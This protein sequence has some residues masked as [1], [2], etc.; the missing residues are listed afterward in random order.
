[1]AA[2]I[3]A[4]TLEEFTGYA[5]GWKTA[6]PDMKGDITN[7]LEAGNTLIEEITWR[8]YT[9]WRLDESRWKH[10]TSHKQNSSFKNLFHIGI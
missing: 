9:H 7:R 8:G 4:N 3:K 2:G 6:F 5:Q 10:N 1:M